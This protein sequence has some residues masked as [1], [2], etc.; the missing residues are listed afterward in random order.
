M[1]AFSMFWTSIVLRLG[2]APFHPG[3]TGVAVF[4]LSR[5]G[6]V[7]VAPLAG[8]AGDRGWTRPATFLVGFASWHSA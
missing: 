3:N 2:Q 7:I 4:A 1:A 5:A 6:G 8:R